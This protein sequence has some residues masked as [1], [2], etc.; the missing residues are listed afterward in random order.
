MP[1]AAI[2]KKKTPVRFLSIISEV[3]DDPAIVNRLDE[4]EKGCKTL[5]KYFIDSL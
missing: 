1:A 4:A 5:G 3:R 2:E